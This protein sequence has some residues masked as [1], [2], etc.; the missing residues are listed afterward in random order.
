M[1]LSELHTMDDKA[2]QNPLTQAHNLAATLCRLEDLGLVFTHIE[3]KLGLIKS[4]EG[5]LAGVSA[6]LARLESQEW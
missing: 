4:L 5:R 1:K 3:T 6:L 2:R